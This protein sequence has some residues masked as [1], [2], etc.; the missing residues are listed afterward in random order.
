MIVNDILLAVKD[1][2]K[3]IKSFLFFCISLIV[4]NLMII[5]I[6]LS[7]ISNLKIESDKIAKNQRRTYYEPVVVSYGDG[8]DYIIKKIDVYISSHATTYFQSLYLMNKFNL[9]A[10]VLDVRS[11]DDIDKGFYIFC[12]GNYSDDA[13][14]KIFYD[15]D[16]INDERVIAEIVRR[17]ELDKNDIGDFYKIIRLKSPKWSS[18]ESFKINKNEIIQILTNLE[19][20]K[21]SRNKQAYYEFERIFDNSFLK[22]MPIE[23]DLLED[24]NTFIFKNIIPLVIF[25][26]L[27]MVYSIIIL[28]NDI[29]KSLQKEYI[30][31]CISGANIKNLF[32]RS[33]IFILFLVIIPFI[34]INYIN[35]FKIDRILI[36]NFTISFSLFLILEI[37]VLIQIYKF[38]RINLLRG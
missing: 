13:L 27:L 10:F 24:E 38:V 2:K 29:F 28:F 6:S 22:V 15:Y 31:H 19:F 37:N 18:L 33:T 34:F 20:N 30:I 1:I 4:V 17:L 21:T 23:S 36:F 12:S 8:I 3:N 7:L 26:L 35:N 9:S 11:S 14:N 25:E 16:L 32:F 5:Q